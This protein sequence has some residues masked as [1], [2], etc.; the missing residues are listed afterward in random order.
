MKVLQINSVCGFG[1]T[2]RIVTDIAS[3]LRENNIES[4]IAYGRQTLIDNDN[5]LKIGNKLDYYIHGGLTRLFD[6]H[7]L[8]GSRTATKRFIEQIKSIDPD[9]IH[10]HN[11]HGYYINIIILFNYLKQTG[12]PVVWTLHDCWSFTGHCAY[13][14]YVKC[15]K[16]I[17]G[18]HKCPQRTSYP[19]STFWD[20][21]K[22]NYNIKKDL[23]T[24][25]ENMT[26][27][28]PSQWLADLVGKSFLSKYPVKVIHNGIDTDIFK[29]VDG[30]PVREK[31][32]IGNKFI[33]LGVASI[34]SKRKGLDYF[35]E[36]SKIID[37]DSI[38]VLVGL[39]EKQIENLPLNIIGLKR[40][41]NILEL[42]QIYSAADVFVNPSVEETFGLVTAEALACG[43]P[44]IVFDSTPGSEIVI[45]D[46]GFVAEP[47]NIYDIKKFIDIIKRNGKGYYSEKCV[48]RVRNKFS[49]ADRFDEY[50]ELFRY[51][52]KYRGKFC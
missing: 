16:W 50:I 27:V 51:L 8:L 33:I 43:I 31:L 34:W 32:K 15:D 5:I 30:K 42:V 14:S 38:I 3:K 7:A 45:D 6:T 29:P 49:K 28:T 11:L 39:D 37:D 12:K 23:F 44:A 35:I 41:S 52:D 9:I 10:I 46:C 13:F 26:I 24:S 47:G 22:R 17:E 18:C 1:S 19:A 48:R 25:L 21:S 4:Y 40:T 36:L 2:G 20:N